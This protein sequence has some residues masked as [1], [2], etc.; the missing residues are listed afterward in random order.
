MG[1]ISLTVL[2]LMKD[3]KLSRKPRFNISKKMWNILREVVR[4]VCVTRYAMVIIIA[5]GIGYYLNKIVGFK[6][7]SI[8]NDVNVTVPALYPPQFTWGN[9][10]GSEAVLLMLPSV[11]MIVLVGALESIAVAKAFAFQFQYVIQPTQELMALGLSNILCS[12]LKGYPVTGS[13]TRSALK[14]Q[15]G[16]RTPLGCTWTGAFVLLAMAV[17]AP[18]FK[19]GKY[20]VSTS[21]KV[22]QLKR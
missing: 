8:T 16:V 11:P 15:C 19:Y 20:L 12:F 13:F 6:G 4:I 10:T 14:A 17:I 7:L 9:H 2:L 22:N 21:S 5:T 18:A 3:L 1:M